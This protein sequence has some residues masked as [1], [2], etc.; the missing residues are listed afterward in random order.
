MAKYQIHAD[1][2][3]CA[4]CLRCQLACSDLHSKAF[5]PA[6]A[7]LKIIVTDRDCAIIFADDCLGCGVCADQCLYGALRKTR[8][9]DQP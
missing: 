9:E 2:A 8:L 1:P 4:W 7:R 6:A 5:N 3:S